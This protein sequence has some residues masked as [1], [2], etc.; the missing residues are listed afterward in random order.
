MHDFGGNGI[1]YRNMQHLPTR[2]HGILGG[3]GS[4]HFRWA[5]NAAMWPHGS[6]V[7]VWRLTDP[8]PFV[9]LRLVRASLLYN[10]QQQRRRS[11]PRSSRK[12]LGS[13]A[14]TVALLSPGS[15]GFFISCSALWRL[16]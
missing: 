2:V 10:M 1:S 13:M 6:A 15:C 16:R 5:L 4:L 12:Q 9:V 3:A 14:A 11:P 7:L 8:M